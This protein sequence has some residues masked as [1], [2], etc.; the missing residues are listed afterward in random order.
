MMS[1]KIQYILIK[2]GMTRV[3]L[4][5][6]LGCGSSNIYGK[7]KRDNFS[8][9]ELREIAE[10]LDCTLNMGFTMNDTKEEI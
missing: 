4:A 3:E 6:K 10:V 5:K 7:L 8:E 2:R 1:E 9:Q